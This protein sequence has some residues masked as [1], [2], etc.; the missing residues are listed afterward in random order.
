MQNRY[1]L[2]LATDYDGTIAHHGVV[3]APTLEALQRFKRTG[4][5]LLLVTGRDLPDLKRV[6]PDTSIFDRIVAENGA[7][8]YEPLT[9][10]ERCLAEPPPAAFV[11]ELERRQVSPLAVGRVIVATW[12]PN[13][14][15]VIDVIRDLGLELQI[16]FNKGA[17]MVLPAG[18]NKAAG[19]AVALHELQ[20]SAP[21]VVG[22]GDAE[23]DHAFLRSCGCAAAVANALPTVKAECDVRLAGDHGAG[24]IEL[25]EM[26]C[27]DD[28]CIVPPRRHGLPVGRDG[29]DADVYLQPHRG[30][31]LI[32]GSSGIGKSTLATALTERMIEKSLEFCIFD[33]EGDYGALDGAVSVGDAKTA[34][35]VRETIDLLSKLSA[36][37]V[38][39]TQALRVPERHAFFAK[40]LP[41]VLSLRMRTGRP[42]WLLIDEAHQLLSAT[43][44]DVAQILPEHFAA[45]I[46]ITVHPE[47][48]LPEA[49]QRVEYVLAL[50]EQAAQVIETFCGV[51]GTNPPPMPPA[52]QEG[53]ILFW[54]RSVGNAPIKVKI[55]RPKQTRNR[56][57]RKYAEGELGKDISFYFRGP[58]DKLNLR[59]QNLALFA[60]IAE[61]VDDATWEHHRRNYD[62]SGWFRT[63]IKD[64][65]LAAEA[66]AAEGDEG[67]D[68][69]ESRQRII[70]AIHRRYTAPS[71]DPR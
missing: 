21:N 43:R 52:P 4:R 48:I 34:P 62:Y 15:T 23:N 59:A 47:A 26:I 49:L 57:V 53:E 20:L 24:V 10:R 32:A 60:Q 55:E 65:E 68:A 28:L 27:R 51:V 36:N 6:F 41:P 9:E 70:E 56:H 35:S 16:I 18:I 46:L 45:T 69:T 42:H 64:D 7:L 44:E 38:I 63:V 22:V 50:G 2:A 11:A 61:G 19:L 14:K 29:S 1:F 40:V 25:M 30:G 71:R 31:V 37:V 66:A 17:V 39:N 54:E 67:L 58:D 3:D 8:L 12:E 5:R 33:A 13:E